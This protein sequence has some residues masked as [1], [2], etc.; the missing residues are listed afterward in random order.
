VLIASRIAD[1]KFRSFKSFA[2]AEK[3]MAAIETAFL[4]PFMLL[5]FFGML[6]LTGLISM[7]RKVSA[8]SSATADLVGQGRLSISN[9]EIQDYF[10]IVNLVINPLPASDVRV[11]VMVYRKSG[12]TVTQQW[13]VDN[14]RGPACSQSPSTA[15]MANLMVAGNDL[16][17]AQT[18]TKY[19]PY[20]VEFMNEQI[21]SAAIFN[22][23]QIV[24]LRPRSS[25]TLDL[26]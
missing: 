16:V 3:G 24:T 8:V 6:D 17:V 22:V 9:A 15:T 2:F 23:E 18:C 25:L 10:K 21:L 19:V 13:V 26:I 5:L 12:S 14:G 7:S 1:M 11:R 20:L 4:L